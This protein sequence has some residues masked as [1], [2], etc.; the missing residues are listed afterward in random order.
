M[1]EASIIPPEEYGQPLTVKDISF[2]QKLISSVSIPVF[3]PTQR[4]IQPNQVKYLRRVGASGIAIGAVVT[5]KN[6][7]MILRTTEEFRKEIDKL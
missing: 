1:I 6:I 3:I 5:S 2:Y 4:K 7:D